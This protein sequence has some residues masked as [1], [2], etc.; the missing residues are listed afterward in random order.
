MPMLHRPLF[1]IGYRGTGKSTVGRHLAE[2]WGCAAV[3]SDQAIEEASG[4]TISEL[5][6]EGEPK[7]REMER[8]IVA[9]LSVAGPMVV[10]LG[11]GAILDPTSRQRIREAGHV[12]WLTAPPDVLAE[13]IGGDESSASRRPSL[14]AAGLLE[15]I[16]AVLAARVPLY[17]EC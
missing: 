1:L 11:G 13:R 5:F 7:F 2:K 6:A 3:D 4:K 15:E 16:A 12:V 17:R 10:S 14:T 9:L 8:Q